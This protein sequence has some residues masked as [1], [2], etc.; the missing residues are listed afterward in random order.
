MLQL[1]SQSLDFSLEFGLILFFLTFS[2][3]CEIHL[4]IFLF[5]PL[6]RVNGLLT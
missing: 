5:Y 1:Y 6:K 2:Q 3:N 4:G